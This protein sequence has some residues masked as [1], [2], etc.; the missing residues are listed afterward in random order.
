MGGGGKQTTKAEIP[1]ELKPLY[2]S[3]ANQMMIAQNA[4]PMAGPSA[5]W[6]AQGR[7]YYG[8][9]LNEQYYNKVAGY[10]YPTGASQYGD[11]HPY[12]L[13]PTAWDPQGGPKAGGQEPNYEEPTAPWNVGG[14]AQQTQQPGPPGGGD[15][16]S[17]DPKSGSQPPPDPTAGM[18]P[19]ER[20][21]YW[22]QIADQQGRGGGS[23]SS[24][25]GGSS[26]GGTASGGSSGSTGGSTSGNGGGSA[27]GSNWWDDLPYS[28]P[29]MGDPGGP[30][31][32]RAGNEPWVAQPGTWRPGSGPQGG[33]E[34]RTFPSYPA[35]GGSQQ[36]G[37]SGAPPPAQGGGGDKRGYTSSLPQNNPY[38]GFISE[39]KKVASAIGG[40]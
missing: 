40:K 13:P 31:D 22:Q 15:T 19:A 39:G 24:S 36:Q 14:Q 20:A 32:P 9:P 34:Q 16:P 6:S 37:K 5:W 25:G 18:T 23:S 27:G 2:R 21:M 11:T 3:T 38:A 29:G 1:D 7:R 28:I 33:G 8:A 35:P 26:G 17:S 30:S 4:N 10:E 12:D